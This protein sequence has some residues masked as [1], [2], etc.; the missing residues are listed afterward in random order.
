MEKTLKWTLFI[1][2]L[3]AGFIPSM[4]KGLTFKEFEE[5]QQALQKAQHIV[6]VVEKATRL[7]TP[8][9]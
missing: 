7:F 2:L 9:I 3:I 1:H 4:V 8:W 5:I 6:E